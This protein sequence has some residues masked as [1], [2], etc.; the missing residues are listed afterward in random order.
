MWD[1]L[2]VQ[3]QVYNLSWNEQHKKNNSRLTASRQ[4][5]SYSSMSIFVQELVMLTPVERQRQCENLNENKSKQCHGFL[6]FPK[7]KCIFLVCK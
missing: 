3:K 4:S 5:F 1:N 2:G 7:N 6:G